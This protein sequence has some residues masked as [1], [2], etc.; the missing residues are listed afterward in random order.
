MHPLI[1]VAVTMRCVQ[2]RETAEMRDALSHDWARLL[3]RM[4]TVP[5]PLPNSLRDPVAALRGVGAQAL[6]LTNGED[7][8]RTPRDRTERR[9]L[10]YAVRARLPVLGVCRGLQMINRYF[11]GDVIP[12]A[13]RRFGPHVAVRHHVHIVGPLE[14]VLRVDRLRVNSF[15]NHGVVMDG[16]A[17]PLVPGAVARDGCIE[18]VRHRSL[19]IWAI[20]WHPERPGASP[21]YD[22]ILI[23]HWLGS[24]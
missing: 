11:G 17:G 14:R 3:V 19:P 23:E 12:L 7:L 4:G 9:L 2:D 16:V 6:L 5:V 10:D 20:Q 24:A 18:A 15:H 13:G 8:G 1:R 21:R 22:R